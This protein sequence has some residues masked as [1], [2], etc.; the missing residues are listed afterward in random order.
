MQGRSIAE[1]RANIMPI[2]SLD[3]ACRSTG[4]DYAGLFA[5]LRRANAQPF[6]EGR[7]FVDVREDVN[8]V[9]RALLSL[10]APGDG[11]FVTELA[12]ETRW[13]GTGLGDE[14]K[15]WIAAKST[16]APPDQPTA[17]EHR[18]N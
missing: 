17:I 5:A 12:P 13:T 16:K 8:A 9:T 18:L 7:W 4:H 3:I 11:L 1:E 15:A 10:C 14:T 2:Y 6:M